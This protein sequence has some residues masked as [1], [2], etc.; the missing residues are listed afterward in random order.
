[1]SVI[2]VSNTDLVGQR[3]SLQ[4]LIGNNTPGNQATNLTLLGIGSGIF[5]NVGTVVDTS[6]NQFTLNSTST[7]AFPA[8]FGGTNVPVGKDLD[9]GA[10][11]NC[12]TFIPA[13]SAPVVR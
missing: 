9:N 7:S 1:M 12:N 2:Y 4:N 3:A 11:L 6:F 10:N 13:G 8:V 5:S